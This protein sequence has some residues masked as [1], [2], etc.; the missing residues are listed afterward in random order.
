MAT[1]PEK[2]GITNFLKRFFGIG[3]NPDKTQ[4]SD[5]IFPIKPE[6]DN[7]GNVTFDKELF[8]PEVQR[9]YNYF[10]SQRNTREKIKDRDKLWEDLQLLY[11]N[12]PLISRAMDVCAAEVIQADTAMIPI[13]V[14]APEDQKDFILK[15]YDDIS[16]YKNLTPTI[17]DI[18]KY[19]NSV[20]VLGMDD[21][22]I[23]EIIPTEIKQLRDR[24]EFTPYMIEDELNKNKIYT[25]YVSIERVKNLI[26]HIKNNSDETTKM[27]KRY[28]IGYQL[29]DY[30]L[31]P[32][33]VIHFRNA[34]TESPFDPFG[35]PFYI[36]AIAPFKMWDAGQTFKTMARAL[37]FPTEK[38]TINLPNVVDPVEKFKRVRQFLNNLD[39]VAF[40]WQNKE[41][42]TM[43]QR[44]FTVKDLME[45]DL[46][47]PDMDLKDMDDVTLREELVVATRL[48]RFIIDPRE[49]GFGEGGSTL[50]EKWKE[51]ARFVFT[52]QSIFLEN[53]SQMTKIHMVLSGKWEEDEINFILSMPF[54]ESKNSDLVE[55]QNRLLDFSKSL[56]DT[57]SEKLFNGQP[58]P[59][60]VAVSILHQMNIFDQTV[61]DGWVDI[62]DKN[63]PANPI[64][65]TDDMNS[66][67]G[68]GDSFMG[69]ALQLKN[70][71]KRF[72][73]SFDDST[74]SAWKKLEES[75]GKK[76]LKEKITSIIF[77][78]RQKIFKEGIMRKSHFYSSTNKQDEKSQFNANLLRKWDVDRVKKLQEVGE[79]S[80]EEDSSISLKEMFETAIEE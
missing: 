63:K 4:P 42:Q 32:W 78:E 26:D 56:M 60:E 73:E 2:V 58:I 45:W 72:V 16:L 23:T 34:T 20:W 29:H 14:E 71:L 36:H 57:I 43:G 10:L 49:T 28:L 31:P 19:G 38:W 35:V 27:F 66:G 67:L 15:F 50:V 44:I 8:P 33:R 62:L 76:Q 80:K 39:N 5:Q 77:K 25:D 75:T 70:K 64:G 47:R 48:P 1:K 9:F 79:F 55:S 24:L 74:I 6:F 37:N 69:E 3:I 18:V 52:I 59:K 30:I 54:P 40:K 65:N 41:D 68:G 53:L 61:I 51:F 21:N 17:K 22:G 7:D 46:V 13:Q 11:Y 12:C